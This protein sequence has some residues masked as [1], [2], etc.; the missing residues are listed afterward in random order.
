MF[1]SLKREIKMNIM[2]ENPIL[3]RS[4]AGIYN[5]VSHDTLCIRCA[6][7]SNEFKER[8]PYNNNDLDDSMARAW[9]NGRGFRLILFPHSK[10]TC[11]FC[12]EKFSAIYS[13]D[14]LQAA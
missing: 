10:Q 5:N 2:K 11:A 9:I 4:E 6:V 3:R 13:P 1:L 8:A 7:E 14:D 12:G